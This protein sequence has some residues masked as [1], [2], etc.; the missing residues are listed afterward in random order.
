MFVPQGIGLLSFVV[1]GGI[2]LLDFDPHHDGY[3]LSQA[4]AIKDGLRIHLDVHGQ[5]GP[6]TPI[7]QS[8]FLALPLS[9]AL[10]IRLWAVSHLSL[11]AFLIADMGRFASQAL[12]LRREFFWAASLLWLI[13]CDSLTQGGFLAWSSAQGTLMAVLSLYL[14]FGSMH[15]SRRNFRL[16]VLLITVS[17]LLLGIIP[18]A[19]INVGLALWFFLGILVVLDFFVFRSVA[20]KAWGAMTVGLVVSSTMTIL[21]LFQNSLLD[22]YVAQAVL[23]PARWA[24][25]AAGS[26]EWSTGHAL[27]LLAVE[28]ALPFLLLVG[29]LVINRR[30]HKNC[31]FSPGDKLWPLAAF[32][33]GFVA[34]LVIVLI[35]GTARVFFDSWTSPSAETLREFTTTTAL[36]SG[37]L[38]YFIALSS[39]VVLGSQLLQLWRPLRTGRFSETFFPRVVLGMFSLGLMVQIVPTHDLRHFWWGAALSPLVLAT[40]FQTMLPL[41]PPS[42]NF[43][44]LVS[45]GQILLLLAAVLAN[46][47]YPRISAPEAS[48]AKGLFLRVDDL[49]AVENARNTMRGLPPGEK[50]TFFVWDGFFATADGDYRAVDKNFVWWAEPDRDLLLY[51]SR[52]SWAVADTFTISH[53]GFESVE[54][55]AEH[56]GFYVETCHGQSCLLSKQAEAPSERTT[57]EVPATPPP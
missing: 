56:I 1:L 16:S 18:F 44:K 20:A 53:L 39:L 33:Q 6:L 38:L 2:S 25:I 43:L 29:F 22:D 13:T 11:A 48:L 54:D 15:Y 35:A 52:S 37:R 51:A 10:A 26:D 27:A 32:F 3:M 40:A 8:L 46:L 42:A 34:I 36:A 50:A 9:E 45:V 17:G 28:M 5:Y 57:S 24:R 47:N 55:F 23:A 21:W 30:H 7:T 49:Q 4:I 19:R 12:G 31:I 14:L 41:A